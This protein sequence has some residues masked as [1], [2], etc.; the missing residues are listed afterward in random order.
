MS[1]I[2]LIVMIKSFHY[3]LDFEYFE[4][5]KIWHDSYKLGGNIYYIFM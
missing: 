3:V 5:D 4:Y 1:T 2:V